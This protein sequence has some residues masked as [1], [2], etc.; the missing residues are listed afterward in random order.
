MYF[1]E[2]KTGQSFALAG[3]TITEEQ[4]RSFAEQYDPLRLHLDEEYAKTTRFGAIIAPGVMS[5]MLLWKQFLKWDVFGEQTVAGKSTKIEWF[6]PVFVGDVLS[7][8]ARITDTRVHNAYNGIVEVT[9]DIYNQ[10]G[11]HVIRDVTETVVAR[12]K[13]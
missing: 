10:K 5:F 9:V 1:E 8:E 12:R 4:V 2:L 3:V 7:G 6:A 13:E 11:G